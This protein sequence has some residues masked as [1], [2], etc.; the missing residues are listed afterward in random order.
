MTLTLGSE[1][2]VLDIRGSSQERDLAVKACFVEMEAAS[3]QNTR[4][5]LPLAVPEIPLE[6][7][8]ASAGA[9]VGQIQD[10]SIT[11]PESSERVVRLDGDSSARLA[12]VLALLAQAD[13]HAPAAAPV[14]PNSAPKASPTRVEPVKASPQIGIS[15]KED[16]SKLQEEKKLEPESGKI[17]TFSEFQKAFAGEYSEKDIHDYWRDACQ[18]VPSEKVIPTSPE[19]KEAQ[20]SREALPAQSVQKPVVP[21]ERPASPTTSPSRPS[22]DEKSESTKHQS[23]AVQSSEKALEEKQSRGAGDLFRA[24][25]GNSP[26]SELHLLLPAKAVRGPLVANGHLADIA[27]GC[28]V[29]LDVCSEVSPGQVE[30]ILNGTF[31]AIAMATL[32]LQMR[33]FFAGH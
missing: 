13:S 16:A 18:A 27:I 7:A 19:R 5:L 23:N 10:D 25:G 4:L 29:Q 1:Q 26:K 3:M 2:R 12:S 20:L 15:V 11:S 30:V 8:V 24:L 17:F 33:I 21:G 9:T 14:A 28:N 32:A 22:R 31:A 6:R